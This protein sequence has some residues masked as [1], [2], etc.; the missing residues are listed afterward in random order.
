M[1]DKLNGAKLGDD[2]MSADILQRL[3]TAE[4]QQLGI[5]AGEAGQSALAL[6]YLKEATYRA[7][8]GAM[9]H[10][11]LGMEYAQTKLYEQAV[12]ALEAALALDPGMTLAR[13]ELGLLLL[14]MRA[15]VRARQVLEP[16]DELG[17]DQAL[18]YFGL[19]LRHLISGDDDAA[20]RE[21]RAGLDIGSGN[22]ALDQDIGMLARALDTL[23]GA[24]DVRPTPPEDNAAWH[25][26]LISTYTNKH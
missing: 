21:L 9:C 20:L 13:F 11:L 26:L 5:N 22:A 3:D 1:E 4:L 2:E 24:A 15:L 18:R 25:H 17:D 12:A 16:L 10:F 23:P 8:A 14:T 6:A 7:D 19:G